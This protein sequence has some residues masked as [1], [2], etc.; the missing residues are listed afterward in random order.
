MI[1]SCTLAHSI[2]AI[3][4]HTSHHRSQATRCFGVQFFLLKNKNNLTKVEPAAKA[5]EK[6]SMHR[7][8]SRC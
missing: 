3:Q 5:L 8:G 6:G 7:S 1:N 4:D 2:Y